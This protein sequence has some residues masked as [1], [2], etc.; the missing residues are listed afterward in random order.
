MAVTNANSV[1]KLRDCWSRKMN[2]PT[3]NI[4]RKKW[5][6]NHEFVLYYLLSDFV[7]HSAEFQYS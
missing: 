4:F 2:A 1:K 6:I 3:Q 5:L 7:L